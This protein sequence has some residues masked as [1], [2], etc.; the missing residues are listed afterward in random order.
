MG[1]EL[2]IS[3]LAR[4]L[5]LTRSTTHR[6][7]ATLA[8]LGYLQKN[9]RTRRYRLG[10]RVLDLGFAA[11]HAMDIREVA[12][13]HLQRLSD[14]TGFTVNMALLDGPEVV[15]IE[16]CRTSRPGQRDIDLNLHVGSRL[17]A[18]CTA[19]GKAMLAYLPEDELDAVL[20]GTSYDRRGPNT[21][22][23]DAALRT[24]LEQI[25]AAGIALNNEELAYGLRSIA[26]PIR[27][28]SG[29]VTAAINL[30]V[31]RS[32]VSMDELVGR[33]GPEVRKTAEAISANAARID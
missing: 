5:G 28:R 7:V 32:M 9:G 22:V 27:A 25:R 4:E 6:Y 20:A 21:L 31:H 15:Y 13:P 33:Y 17:P 23:T 12:Q 26:A 18:Y 2:G 19:L 3:E 8:Q 1:S 29:D 14:A 11:I 24:E 16:R 30:A 10:P